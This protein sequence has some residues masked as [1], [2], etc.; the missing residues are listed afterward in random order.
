MFNLRDFLNKFTNLTLFTPLTNALFRRLFA[1]QTIALIGTGLT[2]VALGLLA[3]QIKP[4]AAG[5][6]L[7]LA[8]AIKMIAYLI[9]APVAAAFMV[10]LSA[11]TANSSKIWLICLN[12]G[13]ALAVIT[14]FFTSEIWQLLVIIFFLNALAA[15]YTPLYQSLLPSVLPD[16]KS[17][18]QSLALSQLAL[19]I[20]TLLSPTLAALALLFFPFDTLFLLNAV[21]FILMAGI[22]L[23]IQ[24]P[25]IS[26]TIRSGNIW[27]R[28][29]FGIISYLKTPRLRS[30]L[31]LNLVIS[32][33]GAMVIINT[34]VLVKERL[35]LG[36]S[37]VPIL[38][39]ASGIGAMVSALLASRI[40]EQWGQRNMMLFASSFTVVALLLGAVINTWYLSYSALFP[41]WFLLGACNALILIPS[42]NLVRLSCHESDRNDFFAA[43]FSLTHGMWLITYLLA[44]LGGSFFNITA[45]FIILA[46]ISALATSYAVMT[47]KANEQTSLVHTHTEFT[48]EHWHIH[49]EHH[50]HE[51]SDGEHSDI[52]PQQPHRHRHT[53]KSLTHRH[54][55]FID[56][57]HLNWPNP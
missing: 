28:L 10:W 53:H 24:L 44:G 22:L 38:L 30:N 41:I 27:Q 57:H 21:A 29:S 50:Q 9:I 40:I 8:M 54:T 1:A 12:L 13:R 36:D 16:E 34:V 17:Y 4:S 39:L 19:E 2:T 32:C 43:N 11:R 46:A 31:A 26:H 3:Y 37:E 15:C 51:H 7:G 5:T 23:P 49:D 42:A 45:I 18:T 48:H 20:E 47:W 35:A 25:Q 14:L 56:E 33:G 55:F 52:D 6:V